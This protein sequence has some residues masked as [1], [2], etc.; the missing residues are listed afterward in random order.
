MMIEQFVLQF[1]TLLNFHTLLMFSEMI[2]FLY[3]TCLPV[4]DL[5][6]HY[7]FW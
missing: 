1:V 7:D 2:T 5:L 4:P 6:L 3:T